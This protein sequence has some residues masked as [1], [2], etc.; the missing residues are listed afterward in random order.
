[1]AQF[2]VPIVQFSIVLFCFCLV[3]TL[4]ETR[5]DEH[6]NKSNVYIYIPNI[7]K[8]SEFAIVMILKVIT[9]LADVV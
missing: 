9:S 4:S 7:T 8:G 1:M 6:T 3:Q 5:R 2:F